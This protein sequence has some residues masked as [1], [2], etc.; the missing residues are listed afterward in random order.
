MHEK[1]QVSNL[2]SANAQS[3]DPSSRRPQ[4][5]RSSPF[6]L[7]LQLHCLFLVHAA[8]Q[9]VSRS[10]SSA[11][12]MANPR[13]EHEL[14]A[15]IDVACERVVKREVLLQSGSPAARCTR[16]ELGADRFSRR[17]KTDCTLPPLLASRA[18]IQVLRDLRTAT[19]IMSRYS[20]NSQGPKIS[21][22]LAGRGRCL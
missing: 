20:P 19:A 11:Q 7:L 10:P 13:R 17:L 9:M 1:F 14:A 12:P 2:S 3:T 8:A 18:V 22:S 15:L 6:H 21:M 5:P 4:D 16:L